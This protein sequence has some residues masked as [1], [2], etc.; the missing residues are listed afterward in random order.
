MISVPV[1]DSLDRSIVAALQV[2]GRAGW[3]RIASVIDAPERTV[4]ARGTELLRTKQVRLTGFAL[5]PG[6]GVADSA[7]A[8]VRCASGM[9]RMTATAASARGS[10][11]FCYLTTGEYDCVFELLNER[12][13][14]LSVFLDELPALPGA[15]EIET[16]SVLKLYKATH[17]WLPGILSDEQVQA[18]SDIE[19]TWEPLGSIELAPL[20][21]EEREMARVLALDGRATV[22]ELA[23]ATA[24]SPA[25]ARRRLAHLQ[26]SGRL[27]DRAVIEPAA[28][29]FPVEAALRI[30]T[31]PG[32][33]E[34]LAAILA[35]L[36]EVRYLAFTT[37]KYQLFVDI[38]FVD[39]EAL[40]NFLM[41][42]EWTKDA[43]EVD[44]SL[45]LHSLK[46]SGMHMNV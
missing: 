2:N 3:R 26:A 23:R 31:V 35:R 22:E 39:N 14:T 36:P 29:G 18:L 6:G 8:M 33:A 30:R 17:Q 27:Y 12:S 25:S 28:L 42:G 32:R 40:A 46:R 7:I 24:L 21:R 16:A 5:L 1:L 15:V 45:V 44:T 20:S 19:Q 11:V 4:A 41:H 38:A 34:A 13:Q 37:G 10:T 43:M 9:S